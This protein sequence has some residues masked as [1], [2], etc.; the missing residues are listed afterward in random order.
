MSLTSISEA[1]KEQS[2]HWFDH[3][4]PRW[5]DI[6]GSYAGKELFVV[7]GDALIQSVLDDPLLAL[8]KPDCK[9]SNIVS[10]G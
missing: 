3:L 5:V 6:I 4:K 1:H 9:P 10:R 7:D 2:T 8:G